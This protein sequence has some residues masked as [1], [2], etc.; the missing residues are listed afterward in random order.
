MIL[1]LFVVTISCSISERQIKDSFFQGRTGDV[2]IAP[3][4]GF[5]NGDSVLLV[6]AKSQK[7]SSVSDVSIADY[8]SHSLGLV[9]ERVEQSSHLFEKH[10]IFT[11]V[12]VNL[13]FVVDSVGKEILKRFPDLKIVDGSQSYHIDESS[14]SQDNVALLTSIASGAPVSEHGIPSKTWFTSTGQKVEA[15][16]SSSA[17]SQVSNIA[18]KLNQEF[19]GQSLIVSASSKFALAAAV[20]PNSESLEE[21]S[22]AYALYWNAQKSAFDSIYSN[23]QKVEFGV[24]KKDIMEFGNLKKVE[25]SLFSVQVENDIVTLTINGKNA[26]FLL[27]DEE[28]FTFLAEL[29]FV[30][31]TVSL[32]SSQ[33]DLKSKVSDNVPD[34]LCFSFGSFKH[35]LEYGLDSEKFEVALRVMDAVMHVV[36][37]EITALYNQDR[38]LRE[39]LFLDQAKVVAQQNAL[40]EQVAD[41]LGE[42][43][44]VVYGNEIFA[45]LASDSQNL[46]NKINPLISSAHLHAVC[47]APKKLEKTNQNRIF[48]RAA[49]ETTTSPGAPSNITEVDPE[50]ITYEEVVAFQLTFWTTL[51]FILMI[52][53]TTSYMGS[54]GIP[55]D[56]PLIRNMPDI[57]KSHS[58]LRELG[59]E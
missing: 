27:S 23:N 41:A 7:K 36:T 31:N 6:S 19:S 32:L 51:V 5:V 9:P 29:E 17:S 10:D 30:L 38:V 25:S 58:Q 8:I 46:C 24:T 16:K 33:A 12:R 37:K 1:L 14:A 15:F 45:L 35:L 18:D 39:T 49:N 56:S 40:I 50:E 42:T 4:K 11:K 53:F 52:I 2:F 44:G 13:M 48:Y 47:P 26:R 43:Q 21:N 28:D 55:D 54:L 59:E 20:S 57:F 34:L 22:N 3:N